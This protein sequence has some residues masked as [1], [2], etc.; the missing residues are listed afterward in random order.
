MMMAF[1][2]DFNASRGLEHEFFYL[3]HH[4]WVIGRA[5]ILISILQMKQQTREDYVI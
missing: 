5:C 2:S 3:M 4:P 1:V